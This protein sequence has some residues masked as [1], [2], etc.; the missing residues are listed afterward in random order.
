MLLAIQDVV[1]TFSAHFRWVSSLEHYTEMFVEHKRA[2]E[3]KLICSLRSSVEGYNQSFTVCELKFA[4]NTFENSASGPDQITYEIENLSAQTFECILFL[5]D[6]IFSTTLLPSLG[7]KP[8]SFQYSSKIKP[9]QTKTNYRP[10]ALTSCL[11]KL[12]QKMIGHRFMSFLEYNGILDISWAFG[13][14]GQQR[15]TFSS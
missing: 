2:A 11:C 13:H 8:L 15:T 7:R 9:H 3:S 5:F 6:K 4:L 1:D 10:I 14:G 12:L